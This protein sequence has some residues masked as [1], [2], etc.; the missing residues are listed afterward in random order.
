MMLQLMCSTLQ[1]PIN[2]TYSLGKMQTV[3]WGQ[4]FGY[5]D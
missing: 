5:P 1:H 3:F 4:D 2:Q